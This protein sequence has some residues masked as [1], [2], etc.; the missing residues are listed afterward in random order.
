M[1]FAYSP[2]VF[3]IFFQKLHFFPSSCISLFCR[4]IF[5]SLFC[6]LFRSATFP[7][8]TIRYSRNSCVFFFMVMEI[9]F[10]FPLLGV[11]LRHPVVFSCSCRRIF[12]A[13]LGCM[14]FL[15]VFLWSFVSL[16]WFAFLL[17]AVLCW[18]GFFVVASRD[19][20]WARVLRLLFRDLSI[21]ILRFVRLAVGVWAPYL[22]LV[23]KLLLWA[24]W[25]SLCLCFCVRSWA[26]S[27]AFHALCLC[28]ATLLLSRSLLLSWHIRVLVC[29]VGSLGLGVWFFIRSRWICSIGA[30]SHVWFSLKNFI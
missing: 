6:D 13:L 3:L 28:A 21:Y 5:L 23:W 22:L 26:S 17:F 9:S 8:N 14:R 24:G 16:V 25:S 10:L 2:L 1:N 7:A 12:A 29:L 4:F 18:N 27:L 11:S 30:Y 19:S 20:H 15:V